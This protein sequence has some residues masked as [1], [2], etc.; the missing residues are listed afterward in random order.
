MVKLDSFKKGDLAAAIT[1]VYF[2]L[3]RLLDSE[4]G[5]AELKALSGETSKCVSFGVTV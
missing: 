4:E 5:I 1:E 2:H 3:D